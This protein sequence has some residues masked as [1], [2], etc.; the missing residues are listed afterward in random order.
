MPAQNVLIYAY[1][2]IPLICF[3]PASIM[4]AFSQPHQRLTAPTALQ[5]ALHPH[6]KET[7]IFNK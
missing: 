1:F 3:Y 5:L 4:Y 7:F 2:N 6:N